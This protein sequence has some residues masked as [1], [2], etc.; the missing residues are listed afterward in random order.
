MRANV[1]ALLLFATSATAASGLPGEQFTHYA[2]FDLAKHTLSDV[3]AR[4]GASRVRRSGD[5]GESEAWICYA[6][7]DGEVQFN[8][9]EMGGGT[10]LL[11]FTIRKNASALDCPTAK[12]T[13]PSDIGGL[14][15]GMT[16]KA[17]KAVAG[18]GVQWVGE[19]GTAR[20]HHRLA[21]AGQATLDVDITVIG[22]FSGDRLV[23]FSV[24]KVE[25]T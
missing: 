22:K 15:V 18:A 8:S 12:G 10:D 14:K 6:T 11:G 24:W 5:G 13:L 9:G 7:P 25:A 21:R 1:L 23:K 2:G 4:F 19:E 16:R 20:F 3:Q 17:F